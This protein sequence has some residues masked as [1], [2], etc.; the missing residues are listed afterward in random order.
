MTTI[1]YL[2]KI[3]NPLEKEDFLKKVV[4]VYSNSESEYEK[5]ISNLEQKKY[6][7]GNHDS[8]SS[9]TFYSSIFNTWENTISS[10]T[11]SDI[12]NSHRYNDDI[13]TL[14]DYLINIKDI[15][16]EKEMD[17]F[18]NKINET[19]LADIFQKYK[20]DNLV[21]DNS[22][23]HISSSYL[24]N[25]SGLKTIEH[26]LYINCESMTIYELLN[27]F[28]N[29]CEKY[30]IP[31]YF[32]YN[33]L[34]NTDECIVIYTNSEY[35]DR[36]LEI[37]KKSIKQV[38]IAHI[39]LKNTSLLV[40][41]ISE[42]IG[43]GSETLNESYSKIRSKLIEDAIKKVMYSDIKKHITSTTTYKG[44]KIQFSQFLSI[45]TTEYFCNKLE[46]K[47]IEKSKLINEPE[48][49]LGY[50]LSQIKHKVLKGNVCELINKSI[51]NNLFLLF[52]GKKSKIKNIEMSVENNKKVIF[53]GDDLESAINKIAK[54]IFN[55]NPELYDELK[56]EIISMSKE[57]GVSSNFAVDITCEE[58]LKGINKIELVE[59]VSQEE[60]LAVETEKLIDKINPEL[61]SQTIKTED[62]SSMIMINYLK[63]IIYPIIPTS[64]K[65]IMKDNSEVDAI[66][67][68]EKFIIGECQKLYNGELS[69]YL[70]EKTKMN[71]GEININYDGENTKIAP[72]D[73][74]DYFTN[75]ILT[76]RVTYNGQNITAEEYIIS[77]FS[78]FIP[79]NGI[80]ILKDNKEINAVKYIS[81][82]LLSDIQEKYQG[83]IMKILMETTKNNKNNV[84]FTQ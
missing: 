59:K 38:E 17:D 21:E 9:D 16:T 52:D 19:N 5:S 3:K 63:N 70:F 37:L 47:Y 1:N 67:F 54:T 8:K 29:E 79:S 28:I 22:Y 35:L 13:S 78:D 71:K 50:S 56:L 20:W 24:S 66:T 31:F 58:L 83:N 36:H 25:D 23:V 77:Y 32:K 57:K 65:F 55:E 14:K 60:I 34:C 12:Q 76:K 2:E 41:E 48:L 4:E 74:V 10:L 6:K 39:Y 40:G 51:I 49:E 84:N 26:G 46:K 72:M 80:F 64:G 45:L 30:D 69:R 68:I 82:I 11:E 44:K 81:E 61:I 73:I 53:T 42:K 15:K 62:G 75:D 18:I 27:E 7:K 43:Y 33:D